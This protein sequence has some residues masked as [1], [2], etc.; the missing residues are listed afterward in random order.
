[1]GAEPGHG[2]QDRPGTHRP[3]GR[4]LGLACNRGVLAA[5]AGDLPNYA[6]AYREDPYARVSTKVKAVVGVYGPYDLIKQWEHDLISRPTDNPT[7]N[8]M[9][10]PPMQD[11]LAWYAASPVAH[12]TFANN[13][14]AFLPTAPTTTS[15][16]QDN[17][18]RSCWL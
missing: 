3:N 7:Q 10:F 14:T 5:L 11:R 4:L 15:L 13:S 2:T 12:A 16:T 6:N 18:K 1:M 17:Q 8:L 9:G